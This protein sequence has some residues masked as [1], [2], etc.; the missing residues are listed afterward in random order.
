MK[1]LSGNLFL[2]LTTHVQVILT[3]MR[4]DIIAHDYCMSLRSHYDFLF[5]LIKEAREMKMNWL[6][7]EG[8]ITQEQGDEVW[9][10]PSVDIAGGLGLAGHNKLKSFF[11]KQKIN[12]PEIVWDVEHSAWYPRFKTREAAVIF[13][14]KFDKM[15]DKLVWPPNSGAK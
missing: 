5:K 7:E 8:D 9:E 4:S 1:L 14:D 11:I 2:L 15:M 6:F 12:S 13:I 10:L 3:L